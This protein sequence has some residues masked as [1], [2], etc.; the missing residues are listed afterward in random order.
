MKENSEAQSR[1]ILQQK[2]EIQQLKTQLSYFESESSKTPNQSEARSRD[3]LHSELESCRFSLKALQNEL[4]FY[5][6]QLSSHDSLKSDHFL[7][8]SEYDELKKKLDQKDETFK[9][10]TLKQSSLQKKLENLTKDK[11]LLEEK[12]CEL[13]SDKRKLLDKWQK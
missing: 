5:K 4:K 2:E 10:S 1:T 12:N 9:S 11:K 3:L 7:L 8:K 13:E 6:F